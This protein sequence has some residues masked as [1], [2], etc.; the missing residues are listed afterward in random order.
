MEGAAKILIV[1]DDPNVHQTLLP[2]LTREGYEV[3]SAFNGLDGLAMARSLSP[4]IIILDVMLPGLD[5]VSVCLELNTILPL[6]P[7]I[8]L[9]ARDD[10]TDTIVGLESGADGYITKPFHPREVVTRVKAVL[11]RIRK[12]SSSEAKPSESLERDGLRLEPSAYKAYVN[13]K[14]V[15]L[16]TTEFGLLLALMEQAGVVLSR[17][18][19]LD[20]VWG[21]DFYGSE[22]T[23]D[24]HI[25]NLRKKLH[26]CDS[27]V[28]P[29]ESVRGV[30]YRLRS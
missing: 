22:R 23:V 9:S 8:M 7:V 14:E 3:S 6:V 4:S 28:D 29:V 24:S 13:D 17:Q 19:L 10:L 16:T 15:A 25:R 2:W 18:T 1:D 21:Q 5:G 11:R 30:G 27:S 20:K 26:E 12:I